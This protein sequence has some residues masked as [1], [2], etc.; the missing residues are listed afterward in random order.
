MKEPLLKELYVVSDLRLADLA[1]KIA[2]LAVLPP[3]AG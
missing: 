3:D 1:G 2:A